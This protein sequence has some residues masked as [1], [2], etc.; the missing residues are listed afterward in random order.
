[1]DA[2]LL[3][4]GGLVQ[5]LHQR[6]VDLA[7]GEALLLQLRRERRRQQRR[8]PAAVLDAVVSEAVAV[9]LLVAK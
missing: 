3:L 1:M 4:E 7:V 8:A 9:V 6:L 2:K 5:P